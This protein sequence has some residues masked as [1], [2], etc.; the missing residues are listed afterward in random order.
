MSGA[1]GG[2]SA[3]TIP[4]HNFD[5]DFDASE[6]FLGARID[7]RFPPGSDWDVTWVPPTYS[8]RYFTD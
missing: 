1:V 2:K 8:F 5:A 3:L 6:V 4:L 7:A